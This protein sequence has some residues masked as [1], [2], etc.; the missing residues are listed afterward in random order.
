MAFR[1]GRGRQRLKA[2]MEISTSG[3]KD[4]KIMDM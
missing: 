4:R 1:V 2:T 3:E